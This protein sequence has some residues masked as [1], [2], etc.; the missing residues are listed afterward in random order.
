MILLCPEWADILAESGLSKRDV[1]RYVYENS[2]AQA[3]TIPSTE[4]RFFKSWRAGEFSNP[5]PE[6]MVPYADSPQHV[7]V[8]IAGGPGDHSTHIPNLGGMSISQTVP[9]PVATERLYGR[10]KKLPV[11]ER[12]QSA[13]AMRAHS[14]GPDCESSQ[15]NPNL[16][17]WNWRGSQV[18]ADFC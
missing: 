11:P 3:G 4:Y 13:S 5:T 17:D 18:C 1:Q 2:M 16:I 14:R 9:S 7:L 8:I 10:Y 15:V 12:G 6:T